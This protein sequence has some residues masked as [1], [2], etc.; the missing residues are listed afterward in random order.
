MDFNEC[1]NF[2]FC[3]GYGNCINLFGSFYCVCNFGY[4]GDKC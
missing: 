4:E 3:F 2:G 1:L